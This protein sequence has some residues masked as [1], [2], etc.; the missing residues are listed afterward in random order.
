[1]ARSA[2]QLKLDR[3]GGLHAIWLTA[4][5]Y[6]LQY[7]YRPAG[8]SWSSPE[9]IIAGNAGR[10]TFGVDEARTVH[11]ITASPDVIN[12]LKY[13]YRLWAGGWSAAAVVGETFYHD[14]FALAVARDGA[15]HLSYLI[16]GS[17]SAC[18]RHKPAMGDWQACVNPTDIA[19][20]SGAPIYL[21][22][23]ESGIVHLV[24]R[25]ESGGE[26]LSYKVR[27]LDG[28]WLRPVDAFLTGNV[29]RAAVVDAAGVIHIVWQSADSI[30]HHT[31]TAV[32]DTPI[33]YTLSQTVTIPADAHRPTLSLLYRAEDTWLL[34]ANQL[35]VE[36]DDGAAIS[37]VVSV[38]A[39]SG[40]WSQAWGDVS[41]WAGQPVTVNLKLM[42]AIGSP[43]AQTYIDEVSLGAWLTPIVHNVI[44]DRVEAW[45]T[46][47]ITITGGNFVITPTIK[48]GTLLVSDVTWLN[49]QTLTATL[50]AL[51]PGSYSV[52][53]Y[54]PGG[55]TALLPYQVVVGKQ[56]YLPVT[57]R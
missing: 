54:N 2:P 10:S 35:A 55:Q 53:V 7:G 5:S 20:Y 42:Q 33:E 11:V 44:P 50:P 4:G 18:Y 1:M 27:L 30:V 34:G 13:T 25:G 41:A 39:A 56:V 49:A 9:T 22:V 3:S 48:V 32:A 15:L 40:V 57:L 24:Y 52:W 17:T 38:K 51:A 23:T 14:R 31:Q 26:W 28:T 45:T 12:Q 36:I 8:G 46:L 19:E 6:A 47:P 29:P 43:F 16:A 21:G 37:E